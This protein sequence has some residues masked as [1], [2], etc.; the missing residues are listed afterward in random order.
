M[1]LFVVATPI[2]NLADITLRALTTLRSVDL[3]AAEDTRHAGIL[4]KKYDIHTPLQSFHAHSGEGVVA[5]YLDMLVEG[6][7]IALISDAGTPG[8]SDPGDRLLSRAADMGIPIVPVPGAC[9]AIAALMGSG[10]PMDSFLYMGF[11][12]LKKG[13]QTVLRGLREEKRTVVVYESVHR[14]VR[15]L[16]EMAAVLGSER[17]CVVARELTKLHEE[18]YRGT[19]GSAAVWA[20]GKTMRGEFVLVVGP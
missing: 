19:L 14:V 7:S 1:P 11:L 18:F 16:T 10:L 6:K 4:W 2:G 20:A 3:V 15:T 17:P 13:R 12:P 8:I 9:A 5:R